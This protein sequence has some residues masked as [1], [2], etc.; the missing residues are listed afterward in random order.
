MVNS[1]PH[2][3]KIFENYIINSVDTPQG[4]FYLY[5]YYRIFNIKSV[6]GESFYAFIETVNKKHQDL[7]TRF[8]LNLSSRVGVPF[9]EEEQSIYDFLNA[10]NAILTHLPQKM[11]YDSLVKEGYAHHLARLP[12][13]IPYLALL[14]VLV[15]NFL[16]LKANNASQSSTIKAQENTIKILSSR[17]SELEE[18]A[19]DSAYDALKANAADQIN[20]LKVSPCESRG[21]KF[22]S[23][24]ILE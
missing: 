11:H 5:D 22:S 12:T 14:K 1:N 3:R 13:T 23:S 10:G 18:P 19:V 8:K 9:T 2:V 6:A 17:V 20:S 24:K 15:D 7:L 21:R 16:T 4:T